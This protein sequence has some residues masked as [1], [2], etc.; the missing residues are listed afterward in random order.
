MTFSP[1]QNIAPVVTIPLIDTQANRDGWHST[2]LDP[3]EEGSSALVRRFEDY[4]L[5]YFASVNV[6]HDE[7]YPPI[8]SANKSEFVQHSRS[9]AY[10]LSV[11]KVNL[12]EFPM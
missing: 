9:D 4:Y 6:S 5:S 12:E 7:D 3:N 8:F 1:V 10:T 2:Q 11:A